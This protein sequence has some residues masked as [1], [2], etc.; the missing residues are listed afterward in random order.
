MFLTLRGK[1]YQITRPRM[2]KYDGLCDSHDHKG[3]KI[4]IHKDLEG[5]ELLEVI[6]HEFLHACL[7]DIDEEVV[8]ES[9]HDIAQGIKSM[10]V[11]EFK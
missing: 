8:A 7:W 5:Y 2:T 11:I 3:K 9:A 4:R 6:I 10:D 1:R